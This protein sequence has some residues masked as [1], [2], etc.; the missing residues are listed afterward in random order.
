MHQ[1]LLMNLYLEA[2][3]LETLLPMCNQQ[4]RLH[5]VATGYFECWRYF[6]KT[7]RY[8][9]ASLVPAVAAVPPTAVSLL[10]LT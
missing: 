8:F 3:E 10:Q 2:E 7:A 1:L 9:R 6:G 5:N 4:S